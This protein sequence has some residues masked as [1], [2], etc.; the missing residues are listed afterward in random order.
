MLEILGSAG[1]NLYDADGKLRTDPRTGEPFKTL[2]K[3]YSEDARDL[4]EG[5]LRSQFGGNTWVVKM[6]RR[7]EAAGEE[8]WHFLRA[9][10]VGKRLIVFMDQLLHHMETLQ[11]EP[12]RKPGDWRVRLL[13]SHK[14]FIRSRLEEL[15]E[16]IPPEER[17]YPTQE[18]RYTHF[19]AFVT[20]YRNQL[21]ANITPAYLKMF[22]MTEVDESLPLE[23]WAENTIKCK[24]MLDKAAGRDGSKL[25]PG[26][27]HPT[28]LQLA[29]IVR[30][31]KN[32]HP[33]RRQDRPLKF[34]ISATNQFCQHYGLSAASIDKILDGKESPG[35][36]IYLPKYREILAEYE[37]D[38][39]GFYLTYAMVQQMGNIQLCIL[40]DN[41][42]RKPTLSSM[43]PTL[44]E[45]GQFVPEQYARYFGFNT[46]AAAQLDVDDKMTASRR[47]VEGNFEN[48]MGEN[49]WFARQMRNRQGD[50][51]RAK[52]RQLRPH[53]TLDHLLEMLEFQKNS[54]HYSGETIFLA[55][56][57]K[58]SPHAGTAELVGDSRAVKLAANW[59]AWGFN[60]APLVVRKL[61]LEYWGFKGTGTLTT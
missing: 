37:A 3:K 38:P 39:N 51:T 26:W 16:F 52:G 32:C 10:S 21:P 24:I 4:L 50:R 42:R 35:Y 59:L 54:C 36:R 53:V 41:Q 25:P 6:E 60:F 12:N 56:G 46:L 13:D 33:L 40:F 17:R 61:F 14:V 34:A 2:Q 30:M 19:D 8:G 7:A 18:V 9:D 20:K 23:V 29:N 1:L 11:M 58:R 15:T 57:G 47:V 27:A 28:P 31:Y 5:L 48:S 55:R 44:F 49:S 43:R 45:I 22:V